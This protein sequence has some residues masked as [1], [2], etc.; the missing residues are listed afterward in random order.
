MAA[1]TGLNGSRERGRAGYEKLT[2]TRASGGGAQRQSGKLWREKRV[3][4]RIFQN[5]RVGMRPNSTSDCGVVTGAGR[6]R[7]DTV[8]S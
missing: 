2:S 5:Q 4:A 6:N 7:V 8:N 3:G 1:Y